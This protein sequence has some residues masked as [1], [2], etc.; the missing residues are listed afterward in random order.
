M[1]WHSASHATQGPITQGDNPE[2]PTLPVDKSGY[3][4]FNPVPEDQLRKL[5]ERP[6]SSKSPYTL[7]AGHFQYKTD[8]INWTYDRNNVQQQ[9]ISR[10]GIGS[11][12]LKLGLTNATDLE[13]AGT[14]YTTTHVTSRK[15]KITKSVQ[16]GSDLFVRLKYNI[17]GN[18]GGDYALGVMPF[19]KAPTGSTGIGNHYWEGGVYL[20]GVIVLPD[21]WD[22]LLETE[23]DV[24]ENARPDGTHAN[25]INLVDFSHPISESVRGFIEF[26][27]DV[28]TDRAI[29][30]P[31]YVLTLSASWRM[32]ANMK[33]SFGTAIGL[34][35]AAPDLAPNLTISQRF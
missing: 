11:S 28:N 21:D 2:N 12:T 6:D 26:S 7:D 25:Y 4:L 18:D 20:P 23:Y 16:G 8:L 27:S 19:V 15:T 22:M 32:A 13:L 35:K 24:L 30:T 9:T 5:V 29:P 3:T 10:V 31:Q 14:P 33:V 17:F 34:N 1:F